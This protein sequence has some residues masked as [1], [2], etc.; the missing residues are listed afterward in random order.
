MS[1]REKWKFLAVWLVC[2][3]GIP[4]D[5]SCERW[6]ADLMSR[7]SVCVAVVT[8]SIEYLGVTL[9]KQVED[10]H[11]KNFTTFV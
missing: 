10:L 9:A 8:N 3:M 4:E 1:V 5:L 2:S 6:E 7:M 11:N